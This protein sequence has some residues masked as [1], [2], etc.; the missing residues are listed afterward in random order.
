MSS[1]KKH[2]SA[3]KRRRRA[4]RAARLAAASLAG[5][6][7]AA[8]P[9]RAPVYLGRLASALNALDRAGLKVRFA[10]GGAVTAAGYVLRLPSRHG[11]AGEHWQVRTLALTEFTPPREDDL[12][13]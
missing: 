9:A 7:P 1:R 8:V 3:R 4:K 5:P 10:H 12:D 11:K 13:D 2:G 6:P